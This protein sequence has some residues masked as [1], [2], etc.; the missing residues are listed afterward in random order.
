MP[1]VHTMASCKNDSR[2]SP[3][4][5]PD[6][7]I[8]QGTGVPGG[9]KKTNKQKN[10]NQTTTTK[11]AFLLLPIINRF[12]NTF[13][14]VLCTIRDIS[15][16]HPCIPLSPKKKYIKKSGKKKKNGVTKQETTF[17]AG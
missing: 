8:G 1:K 12:R 7:P 15:H 2:I 9:I 6:D 4:P 16:K 13:I 3:L 5:P 10:N 17:T 14:F 11:T